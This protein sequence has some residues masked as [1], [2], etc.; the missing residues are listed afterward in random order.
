[1]AEDLYAT[2][3]VGKSATADEI[4]SAFRKA[5]KTHH[6]DLNPGNK[7]AEEA[8][9][10]VSAANEILSDPERRKKYDAG[11][12]DETGA[13]RAPP[14]GYREYAD[15]AQGARYS[16][17]GANTQGFAGGADFEDLFGNIFGERGARQAGPR[18][19]HDAQYTLQAAF[20][21]AVNGATR[22]L[23]LPDGQIL[24]VKIPP[25]TSDGDVLRLRGRGAPGRDGGPAGDA[26]IE[27]SVAP[28]AVFK[29]DGQDVSL[30]LPVSLREA[31]LGEK[32]SV[33]TPGG[34]VAMTIKAGADTGTRM[35]L[36][37]RGVPAHGSLAAGDLYVTLEVHLG[38]ADPALEAFLRERPAEQKF[39]P[40][41]G[42][43]AP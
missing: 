43:S 13:E 4:R 6:P 39:D 12:I 17:G 5:A 22:R 38:P 35:R 27:I 40:R 33:P 36:K 15:A 8:F 37:G 11:E 18:R 2:L 28:H 29:R 3:G 25:G 32:I 14:R 21:D 7:A 20:L 42:M 10:K 41:T 16:Y 26:L 19:G 1:M 23:T 30:T 9:K 31:V 34:P 24:D